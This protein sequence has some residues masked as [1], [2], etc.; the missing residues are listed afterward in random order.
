[1]DKYSDLLYDQI[2]NNN[3]GIYTFYDIPKDLNI[4]KL[5]IN[6]SDD[7]LEKGSLDLDKSKNSKNGFIIH[8]N[9]RT[10]FKLDTL[11]HELDHVLRF[12]K[13]DKLEI[14]NKLNYLKSFS[15]FTKAIQNEIDEFITCMYLASDEEIEAQVKEFHGLLKEE[16]IEYGLYSITPRIFNI[17]YSTSNIYKNIEMLKNFKINDVFKHLDNNQINRFFCIY[18]NNKKE[19]DRINNIKINFFKKMKLIYKALKNALSDNYNLSNNDHISPK[20]NKSPKY[21]EKFINDQGNK[22][23]LK[24]KRLINLHI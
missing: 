16:V 4:Y 8:I 12:T 2:K 20:P 5:I 15:I 21:Y 3:T 23:E 1:M 9:L 11:K 19:L 13:K 22:L 7:I 24:V 14:L 18:E 17:A 6:I 10:G